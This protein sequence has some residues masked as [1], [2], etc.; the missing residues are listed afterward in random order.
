MRQFADEANLPLGDYTPLVA[1]GNPSQQVLAQE[2]ELEP[3]LIV[4]GKH[5]MNIT[6]ELLLGSVTKNVLSESKSDVLIVIA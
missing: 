4:M 1:H 3:D 5:G 2:N 6:E